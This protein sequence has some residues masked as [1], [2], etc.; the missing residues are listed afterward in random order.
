MDLTLHLLPEEETR[1]AATAEQQGLEPEAL[2]RKLVS[3]YLPPI[4]LANADDPT[5][6]LLAQWDREDAEMT[7]EEME[8][9]R[10][11]FEEF[12]RNINAERARGGARLIYP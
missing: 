5:L 10:R 12:K 11:D 4:P 1:L 9:A 7:P 3:Q 6:A 8:E 2:A